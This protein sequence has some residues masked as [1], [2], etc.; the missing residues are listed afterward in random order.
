MITTF[1]DQLLSNGVAS[2]YSAILKNKTNSLCIPNLNGTGR[3]NTQAVDTGTFFNTTTRRT[4]RRRTTRRSTTRRMTRRRMTSSVV[5]RV[6]HPF[7]YGNERMLQNQAR[8]GTIVLFRVI[9]FILFRRSEWRN[10]GSVPTSRTEEPGIRSDLRNR[11]TEYRS[12]VPASG[13]D[14]NEWILQKWY[15]L[16]KKKF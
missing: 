7:M 5:D 8:N 11:G 4:T 6:G 9:A 10:G 14:G 16:K 3:E 1:R 13:T 2:T 15:G 12:S